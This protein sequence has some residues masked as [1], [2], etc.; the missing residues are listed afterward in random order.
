MA[1]IPSIALS[2]TPIRAAH[3][4]VERGAFI[5]TVGADTIAVERFTFVRNQFQDARL[6]FGCS[7]ECNG[8]IRIELVGKADAIFET[9]LGV[10]VGCYVILTYNANEIILTEI[11]CREFF[12]IRAI[13][14][15]N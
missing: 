13:S 11:V 1:E 10:Q 5:M 14:V 6:I 8:L 4:Q 9:C 2:A 7:F 3:A 15:V 12:I